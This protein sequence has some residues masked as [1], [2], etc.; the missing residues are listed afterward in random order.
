[1]KVL[2]MP[3]NQLSLI[4]I[5]ASSQIVKGNFFKF[6]IV[7]WKVQI[8]INSGFEGL[9]Q[10]IRFNK[11]IWAGSYFFSIRRQNSSQNLKIK[12]KEKKR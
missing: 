10:S 1:M 12:Y 8:P 2:R 7:P 4:I 3:K 5:I 6:L 11:K 9:L